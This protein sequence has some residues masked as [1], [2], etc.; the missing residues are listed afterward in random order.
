MRIFTHK[1]LG[2]ISFTQVNLLL[3][4]NTNSWIFNKTMQS[5]VISIIC[6]GC[7][8]ETGKC[9]Q[10]QCSPFGWYFVST[11]YQPIVENMRVGLFWPWTRN[12]T[13]DRPLS[14]HFSMISF[15]FVEGLDVAQNYYFGQDGCKAMWDGC[16]G[17]VGWLRRL[18][19]MVAEAI[20]DGCG[21]WINWK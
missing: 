9:W 14:C 17:Y 8:L 16:R 12:Y 20:W 19:G 5:P 18:Y 11:K 6:S 4:Q 7:M 10:A 21:G 2:T 13:I 3:I 15:S 1:R